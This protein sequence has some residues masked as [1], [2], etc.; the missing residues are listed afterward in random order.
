MISL[1]SNAIQYQTI[2]FLRQYL[3]LIHSYYTDQGLN[4]INFDYDK[5]LKVIESLDPNK[6]HCHDDVSVR[7]L[8]FSCPSII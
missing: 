7:M 3:P 8:K 1:A 5:I 4:D 6:A 2:V